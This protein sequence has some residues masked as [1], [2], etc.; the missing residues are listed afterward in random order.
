MDKHRYVPLLISEPHLSR[1][2]ADGLIKANSS[3]AVHGP[4]PSS[5]LKPRRTTGVELCRLDAEGWPVESGDDFT[6]RN[7]ADEADRDARK[8]GVLEW[9]ARVGPREA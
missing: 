8:S 1:F 5:A 4:S 2:V 6:G 7:R 3:R 9:V